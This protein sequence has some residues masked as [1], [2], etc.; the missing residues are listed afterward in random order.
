M[1]KKHYLAHAMVFCAL[2]GAA[3]GGLAAREAGATDVTTLA[4]ARPNIVFVLT[5]D[6]SSNLVTSQFMPEVK[7]L[8]AEGTTFDNYFVTDSLC[9]PSRASIFTGRYPH[10]TGVWGN[11]GIDGGYSAF[12]DH[13]DEASTVATDLHRVGYRTAMMGKYL[14]RYEVEDNSSPGWDEWDVAGWGYPEFNYDINED[15][16]IVH[17]GGPDDPLRD[18][19]LTS[20]LSHLAGSFISRTVH[21]HPGQPFF[22]EVATFAPHSPYTPAPK[23]S[24]LYPNLQYPRT[25]AFDVANTN[26]PSWM[27]HRKPLTPEKLATINEDFRRRAQSVRSVDDLIAH[28]ID[29]LRRTGQLA[30]TYIVFSSDNGLHMG[31]HRLA[32]GKL[33]AFDTDIKVPLVIVGPR[34]PSGLQVNAFAQ[35]IDLRSTFDAWAGTRPNEVVDGRSLEPLLTS[36][37]GT[38]PPGW[39]QGALIEHRGPVTDTHDPDYQTGMSANPVSYEALR[40]PEALYVEYANGQHEYYDLATDPYELDNIYASLSL[41][42]Q[43]ALEA[44]LDLAE[45]CHSAQACATPFVTGATPGGPAG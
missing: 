18:N 20:V 22:L 45:S 8:E 42:R 33:T 36:A 13:D 35:N 43:K 3:V 14:N 29:V 37:P 2:L 40:L 19:Y 17:Y 28:L 23:Y 26:P 30:N 39:P 12:N 15:G 38:V 32:P 11:S 6:L 31:E 10:D 44:Q 7:M 41:K 16:D 25:P 34:V 24:A 4:L 5:D 1:P 21:H 27:G 9:C